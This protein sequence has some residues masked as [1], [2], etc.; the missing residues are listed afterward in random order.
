MLGI[1]FFWQQKSTKSIF[2]NLLKKCLK[3]AFENF[4][5]KL[6]SYVRQLNCL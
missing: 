2:E 3:T 1:P 5:N 4:S 6:R